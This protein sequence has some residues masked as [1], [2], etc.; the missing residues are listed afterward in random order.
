MVWLRLEE[1]EDRKRREHMEQGY[2]DEQ[3]VK[4]IASIF[5]AL[6]HAEAKRPVWND[7]PVVAAA[8]LAEE[9]GEV[10]KAALDYRFHGGPLEDLEKECAQVGAMALRVMFHVE[11]YRYFMAQA[12]GGEAT[13]AGLPEVRKS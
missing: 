13:D 12:S 11:R 8:V 10:V 7:D 3:R 4:A 9:A 5:D 2:S 6:K 1:R